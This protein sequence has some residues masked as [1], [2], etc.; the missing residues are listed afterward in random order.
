VYLRT[1]QKF[2]QESKERKVRQV[3]KVRQARLV[4]KVRQIKQARQVRQLKQAIK[5]RHVRQEVLANNFPYFF[6]FRPALVVC[7]RHVA[8]AHEEAL[9]VVVGRI[10]L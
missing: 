6:P 5:V 1:K 9:E 10:L 8:D 4:R 7:V 2:T 3:R